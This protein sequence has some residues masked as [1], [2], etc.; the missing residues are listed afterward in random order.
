MHDIDGALMRQNEYEYAFESE[1]EGE[2]YEGESYEAEGEGPLGEAETME[3]AAELL[4]VQSEQELE[5]FLGS[6][7][8]KIG[9]SVAGAARKVG[10]AVV[11]FANSPTGQAL[12]GVLK[13]AAKSA[14]PSIGTAVGTAFGGPLGG[15]LGS[16]AGEGLG[17]VL[18]LEL[19]GLSHEDQHFEVAQ[20]FVR[21]AGEAAQQA[22]TKRLPGS[23]DQQ[24]KAA[25]I[26]AAKEY[27]PGLIR[28]ARNG[29]G[30]GAT[31]GLNG[32]GIGKIGAAGT[33]GSGRHRKHTGRWVRR[34]DT[35]M[36]MGI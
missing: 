4:E 26:E 36:V 10:G 22:T 8:S 3:L 31:N 6:V 13:D 11:D 27:A 33:E 17:S 21:L 2:S 9:S 14:L 12:V 29:N 23:P 5:Q 16:L 34:G 28:R 30:N 19:E 25:F 35:L 15:K 18:G 24:A 1:G 7:L 20:Q 32:F